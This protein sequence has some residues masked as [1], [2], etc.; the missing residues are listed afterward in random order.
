MK[1]EPTGLEVE[2][3]LTRQPPQ[4]LSTVFKHPY[5]RNGK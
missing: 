3:L 1:S 2:N 5:G 4:L